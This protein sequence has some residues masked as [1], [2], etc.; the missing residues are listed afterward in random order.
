MQKILGFSMPL[1]R[2]RGVFQYNYGLMPFR[3]PITTVVGEPIDCP[4]IAKP[5]QEDIDKYHDLYCRG[6][7]HVYDKHKNTLALQRKKSMKIM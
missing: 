7:T 4:K 3:K 6:L 1:I 5:T 2:G